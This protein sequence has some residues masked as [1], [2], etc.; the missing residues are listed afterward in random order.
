[1][2]EGWGKDNYIHGNLNVDYQRKFI[3]FM[4][5]RYTDIV[6][7]L[8]SAKGLIQLPNKKILLLHFK[9]FIS[10]K[11]DFPIDFISIWNCSKVGE[12]MFLISSPTL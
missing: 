9:D 2:I 6:A 5:Y 11:R 12:N 1:M 3:I 7:S 8:L 10:F 4:Q